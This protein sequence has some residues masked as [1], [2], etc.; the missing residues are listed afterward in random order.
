MVGY[1]RVSLIIVLLVIALIGLLFTGRYPRGLY[2]FVMGINRW[3]IR[4]RVY[5]SLMRDEYPPFRLDQGQREPEPQPAP[6]PP[7]APET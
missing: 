1:T 7:P 2:D 4:V 3:G 5:T 6:V